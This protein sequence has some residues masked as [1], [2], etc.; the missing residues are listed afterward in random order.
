MN[1]GCWLPKLESGYLGSE[2]MVHGEWTWVP[3]S[4]DIVSF[5][6][7]DVVRQIVIARVDLRGTHERE[8]TSRILVCYPNVAYELRL[9]ALDQ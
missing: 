9:D 2:E 4:E 5:V 6:D 3:R 7:Q 8:N 1:Q